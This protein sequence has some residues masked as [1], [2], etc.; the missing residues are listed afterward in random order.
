MRRL[1]SLSLSLMLA[2][3]VATA[4]NSKLSQPLN[5]VPLTYILIGED[6]KYHD[7]AFKAQE[8]I[9]LEVG[10][11]QELSAVIEG[12]AVH[13]QNKTATFIDSN[14]PLDSNSVFFAAGMGY[15]LGVKRKVTQTFRN[16]VFKQFKHTISLDQK[17]QQLN[18]QFNF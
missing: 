8:A 3:S 5:S 6:P 15:S 17:V 4:D 14:T 12:S 16:P 11:T 10:L 2:T 13:L 9:L 7:A 18:V 1:A